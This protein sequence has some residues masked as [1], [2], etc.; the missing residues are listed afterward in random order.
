MQAALNARGWRKH[1]HRALKV[2]MPPLRVRRTIAWVCMWIIYVVSSFVVVTYARVFGE[3][4]T[5]TMLL[6]WAISTAQGFG[7]QV[8][9]ALGPLCERRV[10]VAFINMVIP[11]SSQ[12][13]RDCAPTR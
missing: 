8:C 5:H 13:A 4:T 9:A 11:L 12:G 10:L 3:G 2:M 7:I 1:Y 6:S